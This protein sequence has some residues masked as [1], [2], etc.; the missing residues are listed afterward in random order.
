VTD[1]DIP[2]SEALQ[3]AFQIPQCGEIA[4]PMPKPL[5]VTLPTGSSMNALVD[6]SKGIPTDCS[7]N[8]NLMLQMA[9]LMASMECP[10]KVL[11][12][13][14]PLVDIIAGL[15]TPPV[16]A[17]KDFADAAVELAPCFAVFAGIP[18]MVKDLLCLVRSVLNCLLGQ[19]RTVRDLLGGLELRLAEADGNPDLLATLQCA[20]DN[21]NAWMQSLSQSID[22]IAGVITLV[23]IIASVAGQSLDLDLKAP[24]APPEDLAAIDAII[25]VLQGV[26]QAIDAITGG[27][28]A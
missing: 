13:L 25:D 5:K 24:S 7:M 18:V 22:P 19:I 9:P 12:L 4:L 23:G 2:L 10:L 21:A 26:V 1:I 20:K 16:K 3:K 17:L 6:M 28:C 8:F 11:K 27:S 15:P 14:K